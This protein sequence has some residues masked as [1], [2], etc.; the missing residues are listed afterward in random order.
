VS[1]FL[2]AIRLARA[3][4]AALPAFNIV[5]LGM[6]RGVVGAAAS[7]G[8]PVVAQISARVAAHFGAGVLR[9]AIHETSRH[10]G[11]T[12]FV[13]L[14]HC[15]DEGILAE[16]LLA[17]F[18]GIMVD[19]SHLPYDENVYMTRSWVE[20]ARDAAVVVEG[21]VGA[22]RGIEDGIGSHKAGERYDVQQVA[23]FVSNTGVD[24]VGTDIGTVHGIYENEPILDYQAIQAIVSSCDAGFVV[25]GGSGLAPNVLR[26][27]AQ[28]GVAKIN[29][30]TD[31]KV[32]WTDGHRSIL[33]T[34]GRFVEPLA[35]AKAA[36][37]TVERVCIEKIRAI[38]G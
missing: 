11:A 21:E 18:D 1:S 19:G 5:D 16:A 7:L 36:E 8:V 17:G 20:R 37:S 29:F 6:I 33:T 12:V 30:S 4:R 25:H 24:L 27:L 2:E 9:A 15:S 32:A 10:I 3:A 38:R 28:M 31:L 22:I 13:H 23:D 35:A 34:T 14:D 26:R